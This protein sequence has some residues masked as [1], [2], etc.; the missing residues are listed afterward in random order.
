MYIKIVGDTTKY[1]GVLENVGSHLIK[2]SGLIQHTSGFQLFLDDDT[3]I[4][5]YSD[6]IY[7]YND[8][9]LG[10]GVYEYSDNNLSYEEFEA[11]T[12]EEQ[13]QQ[14]IESIITKSVGQDIASL[15]ARVDELTDVVA[16]LYEVILELQ[17]TPTEEK[18]E[19]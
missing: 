16:S 4:G 10:E 3:L 14:K 17:D 6:Y 1:Q 15:K 7:P 18:D 8:P 2:V 13:E 9:N 12:K 11:P 5:D 19:E